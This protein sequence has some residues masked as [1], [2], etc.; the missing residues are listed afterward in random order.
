MSLRRHPKASIAAGLQDVIEP[1]GSMVKKRPS[2]S[3]TVSSEASGATP[4]VAAGSSISVVTVSIAF[5]EERRAGGSCHARL[6]HASASRARAIGRGPVSRTSV[7][8][9]R[10]ETPLLRGFLG[11]LRRGV[12]V[13][14]GL[15]HERRVESLDDRLLGHDALLHVA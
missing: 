2:S 6:P 1:R 8:R 15:G 11:E 13:L 10:P 14:R 12:V 4:A 9:K 5:T 3:Q 7:E